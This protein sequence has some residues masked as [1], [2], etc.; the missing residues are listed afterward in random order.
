MNDENLIS[1]EQRTPSERRENARKAGKASGEA[2]RHKRTVREICEILDT[3]PVTGKNKDK[4][5]ELGVPDDMQTQDVLRLVALQGKAVRGDVQAVKLWLEITGEAPTQKVEVC[6][7]DDKTR[8][9]YERAA[10]AIR[11]KKD[12]L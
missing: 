12:D 9:A 1:N 5:V 7:S 4:L 6:A 11:A 3:L 10:A 8:E 2:R